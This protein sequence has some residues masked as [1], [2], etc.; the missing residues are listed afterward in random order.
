MIDSPLTIIRSCFGRQWLPRRQAQAWRL[1]C[2]TTFC[3]SCF[4]PAQL[5]CFHF[6]SGREPLP[7]GPGRHRTSLT[8][9][10]LSRG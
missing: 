6:E 9:A 4:N 7:A 8:E 5:F 10:A 2:I 3:D 1:Y